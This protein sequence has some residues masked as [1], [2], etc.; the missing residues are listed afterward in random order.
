MESNKI[1]S[2]IVE[3]IREIVATEVEE[4][5]TNP[6]GYEWFPS[7]FADRIRN[8]GPIQEWHGIYP[9]FVMVCQDFKFRPY[10]IQAVFNEF[11]LGK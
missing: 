3:Q 1:H 4:R 9:F 8:G 10:E 2:K 7:D 6:K 11:R 5:A